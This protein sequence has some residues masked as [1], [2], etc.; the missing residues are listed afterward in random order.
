[1]YEEKHLVQIV[2]IIIVIIIILI[3]LLLFLS[4]LVYLENLLQEYLL[5]IGLL[6]KNNRFIIMDLSH[7]EGALCIN[8]FNLVC[9]I[10]TLNFI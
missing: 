1:M 3:I 6:I 5:D 7:T 2:L 8:F 10:N 9:V 4:F